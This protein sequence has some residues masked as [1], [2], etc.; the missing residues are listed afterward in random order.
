MH[1][2]DCNH[3]SIPSTPAQVQSLRIALVLVASFCAVELW[4]SLHSHSLSLLADAGHLVVDVFAIALSLWTATLAQRSSQAEADRVNAIA[5]LVNGVLLLV[6]SSWLGWEAIEAVTDPPV[7]ILG[8]SMA[9]VALIG[10]AVN[11]LN[12]YLL[13]ARAEDNL[14][15]RG[16]FLHVVADAG[17]CL[18]VLIGALLI[19]QFGWLWADGVVS[20]GIA[21]LILASALPLVRQ[22]WASLSLG[23]GAITKSE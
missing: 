3:H 22:S 8:R 5:A 17:S 18:G 11:G 7:E 21:L 23:G 6:V 20:G 10:L 19:E 12:A 14:N 4:A 16:A 13:H 1:S 2:H 15:M 9:I